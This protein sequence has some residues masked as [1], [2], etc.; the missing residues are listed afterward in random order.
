MNKDIYNIIIRYNKP[1]K[2]LHELR[3]VIKD[4]KYDDV[5]YSNVNEEFPSYIRGIICK[6]ENNFYKRNYTIYFLD[7]RESYLL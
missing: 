2:Y 1:L 6:C 5:Y 7:Y 3:N 4:I